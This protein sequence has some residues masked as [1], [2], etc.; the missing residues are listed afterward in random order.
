MSENKFLVQDTK[1][2]EYSSSS[3]MNVKTLKLEGRM[4]SLVNK[5]INESRI[6]I[7]NAC[8]SILV[9]LE[10][11]YQ[12]GIKEILDKI[13]SIINK[14]VPTLDSA[15]FVKHNVSQFTSPT[16]FY[17]EPRKTIYLSRSTT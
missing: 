4:M 17:Y 1:L 8:W 9:T 11:E 7:L 15:M 12:S 13:S 14:N 10:T 5:Q 16:N 6:R 2:E 3:D